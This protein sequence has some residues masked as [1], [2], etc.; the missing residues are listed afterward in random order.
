MRRPLITIAML[1][2]SAPV[3]A[4]D[5]PLGDTIHRAIRAQGPMI[6]ADEY[7]LIRRKCGLPVGSEPVRNLNMTNGALECPDGRSVKDGETVAMSD[8]IGKRANAYAHAALDRPEVKAAIARYTDEKTQA[9]L[10]RLP[11]RRTD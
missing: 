2:P 1:A 4:G 10:R 5:T 6:T 9:A 11:G 7:A 3:I 8:R